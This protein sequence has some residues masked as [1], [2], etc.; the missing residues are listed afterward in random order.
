MAKR[1]VELETPSEPGGGRSLGQAVLIALSVIGML[2]VLWL[3]VLLKPVI[4]LVLIS[5]VLACGLAP[6]V[7]R[8]ERA[9]IGRRHIP[10]TAAILLTYVAALLV[11]LGAATLVIVPLVQESIK[12]SAHLPQYIESAKSWLAGMHRAHSYIPDYAGL[13]DRARSQVDEA[14]KY[15]LASVGA[16]FGVFG[17]II[18]VLSVLVITVY[19][20]AG[21]ERIRDGFLSLIPPEHER[22]ARQ[23]LTKMAAVIGAWLRGQLILAGIIGVVTA[24]GMFALRVPY[25]FVIAVVGAIGEL[26][27]MLGP[28]AAA[29]PAVLILLIAGPLWKLVVCVI[30]FAVLARVE[31]DILAPRIMERQVGISPLVTILALLV[32]ATLLGLVGALLAIPI[33][34]ALQVLFVE[35]VAPAIKRSSGRRDR[36]EKAATAAR[37][38]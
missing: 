6:L 16:A 17:G 8:L 33:A 23:T 38:S 34:A 22:Q 20:L 26:V 5:G 13:V 37:G 15:G 18:S 1:S 2:L 9:R 32:G 7:E 29:I 30:F 35:V 27:P 14:A 4:L 25:P 11:L 28:F 10:R 3:V 12:F 21:Y 36:K 31:G 24:I 19:M